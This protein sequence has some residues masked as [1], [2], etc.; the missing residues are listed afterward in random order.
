MSDPIKYPGRTLRYSYALLP[1]RADRRGM[2][3]YF[4]ANN[5]TTTWGLSFKDGLTRRYDTQWRNKS[6]S[7]LTPRGLALGAEGSYD[8]YL[9]LTDPQIAEAV[10]W[11]LQWAIEQPYGG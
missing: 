1:Y 6:N 8:T 11:G 7:F 5:R 2:L 4:A 3:I 10:D 9:W